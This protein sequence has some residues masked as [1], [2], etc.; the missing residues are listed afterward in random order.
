[1]MIWF[2]LIT[3]AIALLLQGL[4]LREGLDGVEGDHKPDKLLVEPDETFRIKVTLRNGTRRFIPFLRVRERLEEPLRP[5]EEKARTADRRNG[6]SLV[7]LTTWLRPR[8]QLTCDIPVVLARRGRYVL[9]NFTL[10][11]GDFLGL[12]ER[13]KRCG[14]FR[15]VVAAP[16]E[17]PS[18]RL[19]EIFGGFLGEMSV[20]RFILEDPV[21]T[22]GF[23]EYTGREPMKSISWAQSA[24]MNQLMVRKNDYTQEPSAAVILNVESAREDREEVLEIC[25]S[26]AR[27]VCSMLEKEGVRYSFVSN[28]A[29]LGG[30]DGWGNAVDG[31]GERHYQG[32]LERLGRASYEPVMSLARMLEQ[33]TARPTS[34]GRILITVGGEPLPQRPLNRLR[35]A[36]SGRLLILDGLEAAQW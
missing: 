7:E 33:E 26:L 16:K 10:C 22:L 2:L 19:S 31:L 17:L 8:Q 25:F 35:E 11:S 36:A 13:E 14:R 29:L 5:R 4:S 1:M 27:T 15:E 21:L 34:A 28:A 3:A 24:R 9:Q 12:R 18:A 20:T 23:R 6:G 32:I 30:G